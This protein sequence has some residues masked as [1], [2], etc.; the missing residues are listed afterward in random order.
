MYSDAR[1]SSEMR[2]EL[3]RLEAY[4]ILNG[5]HT[6]VH[7]S[8]NYMFTF[9]PLKWIQGYSFRLTHVCFSLFFLFFFF[10]YNISHKFHSS[11]CTECFQRLCQ[12]SRESIL[13]ID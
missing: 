2:F 9:D 6:V 11:M 3:E 5:M 8:N 1:I 7:L 10:S 4:R 13:R 12:M